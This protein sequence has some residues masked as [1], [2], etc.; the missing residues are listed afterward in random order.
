MYRTFSNHGNLKHFVNC[1]LI[2]FQKI[3]QYNKIGL[4][5]E[6][7]INFQGIFQEKS[8]FILRSAQFSLSFCDDRM[9]IASEILPNLCCEAS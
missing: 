9:K 5:Y 1:Y 6:Y 7:L 8:W 2:D 4:V 3:L